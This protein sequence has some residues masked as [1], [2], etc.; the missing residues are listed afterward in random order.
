[1][2]FPDDPTTVER[3]GLPRP[4]EPE[5]FD[6]K[7]EDGYD[8]VY[9]GTGTPSSSSTTTVD[10]TSAT[11]RRNAKVYL[12]RNPSSSSMPEPRRPRSPERQCSQQRRPEYDYFHDVD[13]LDYSDSG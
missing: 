6:P 3:Q 4:R 5:F 7:I 12:N 10:T 9:P 1:M 11:R 13:Y 8:K 2:R